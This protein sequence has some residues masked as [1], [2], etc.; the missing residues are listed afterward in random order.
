MLFP[1]LVND[2]FSAGSDFGYNNNLY[3]DLAILLIDPLGWSDS[4]QSNPSLTKPFTI[5]VPPICTHYPITFCIHPSLL[6]LLDVTLHSAMSYKKLYSGK[7]LP[8]LGSSIIA[9]V[10]PFSLTDRLRW[11]YIKDV[12]WIE[13]VTNV[14]MKVGIYGRRTEALSSK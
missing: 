2:H 6:L 5:P 7:K 13:T 10:Q 12:C 9:N 8:N 1:E 11:V 4:P 3:I 14:L